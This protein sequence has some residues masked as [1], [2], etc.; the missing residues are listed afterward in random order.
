MRLLSRKAKSKCLYAQHEKVILWLSHSP[1]WH[2]GYLFLTWKLL[3]LHKP[4]FTLAEGNKFKI[5]FIYMCVLSPSCESGP[6]TNKLHH[7]GCNWGSEED[8]VHSFCWNHQNFRLRWGGISV[9]RAQRYS[10]RPKSKQ[11]RKEFPYTQLPPHSTFPGLPAAVTQVLN[12]NFSVG[13]INPQSIV[14]VHLYVTSDLCPT[15]SCTTSPLGSHVC[16]RLCG[17]MHFRPKRWI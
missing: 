6:E 11:T 15:L 8:I 9:I 3:R 17:H 13:N 7:L 4:I 5:S 10:C 2:S 12:H 14:T 16:E 1:C